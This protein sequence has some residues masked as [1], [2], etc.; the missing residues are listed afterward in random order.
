MEGHVFPL[1]F[2]QVPLDGAT[3]GRG[4]EIERKNTNGAL[5]LQEKPKDERTFESGPN[6]TINDRNE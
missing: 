6:T 2:R 4:R 5:D 1:S 3:R